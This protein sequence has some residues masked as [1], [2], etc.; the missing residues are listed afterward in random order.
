MVQTRGAPPRPPGAGQA[1]REQR[2]SI[3]VTGEAVALDLRPA[4]LPTRLLAAL[5]DGSLQVAILVSLLVGL[6]QV[7]LDGAASAAA[8]LVAVLLALLVYPVAFETLTRGRT[9]GKMA[10][11]LRVVRDDAGPVGFRQAFARGLTG[12]FLE[13]PGLMLPGLGLGLSFLVQIAHPQ[14]KR[15]GDVLAGTVVLRERSPRSVGPMAAMP[16][17]L[18]GWARTLDLSRLP[19]GLALAARQF[20]SRASELTPGAREQLGSELAGQIA[21]VVSPPPPVGTPGAA[22]LAAVL[23]ER[24]RRAEEKVAAVPASSAA[25]LPPADPSAPA[26]WSRPSPPPADAPVVPQQGFAVPR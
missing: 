8:S 10:L 15:I 6:S 5:I 4:Q 7:S 26:A 12:A 3:V 13:R 16:P 21:A 1:S 23:S 19:D 25:P 11:G 22:Y 24:R 14:G 17:Q 18:A 20:V 9:P 2:V